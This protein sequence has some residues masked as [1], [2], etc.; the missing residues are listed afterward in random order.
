ML[1]SIQKVFGGMVC[2]ETMQPYAGLKDANALLV[3]ISGA[4]P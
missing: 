3:S 4:A 1:H 2:E